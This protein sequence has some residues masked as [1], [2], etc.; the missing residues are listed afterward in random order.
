MKYKRKPVIIEAEQYDGSNNP[1]GVLKTHQ[2]DY[3]MCPLC[4]GDNQ[5]HVYIKGTYDI[6][7]PNEFIIKNGNGE[8]A[9]C[10]P[11]TF[12]NLYEPAE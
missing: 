7:K 11:V 2:C 5:L 1:F 12:N 4:G 8:Y 10:G 3:R 6:A 9:I